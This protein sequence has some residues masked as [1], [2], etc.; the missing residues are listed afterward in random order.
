M[1][2]R[3]LQSEI[4]RV[5][6]R[7]AEGVEAF[8]NTYNKMQASTNLT[9]KEKLEADLKTQIKK[10][11]RLRDQIKTWVASNDI[12][13]KTQLLEN[14]RLIETQMERFK[15]CEKEMKTKA[16]SKEGLIQASK[17]DP[18]AQEK[19]E[20]TQWLR[21]G[22]EELTLQMEQAEAEVETLQGGAKKKKSGATNSRLEDLERLNERRKWHISR[23]EIVLRLLDN[24]SLPVE[25]VLSLKDDVSYF[26]E[27]NTE[28]D[29]DEDE[30]IYDELNLDEEEEKFGLVGDDVDSD[31]ESEDES[32]DIPPRTP[33]KK[34]DDDSPTN[35][36]REEHSP[37][38]RKAG[39]S[40]NLRKSSNVEVPKPPPPISNSSSQPMS[41]IVKN[42]LPPR[43]PI[44]LP[45]RYATAAAAAVSGPPS[46]V[47]TTSTTVHANATSHNASIPSVAAPTN[48][49]QPPA[50]TISSTHPS[51]HDQASSSPSLTQASVSGHSP[52][53]SSASVSGLGDSSSQSQ[54]LSPAISEAMSPSGAP[55]AASSPERTGLATA[56]MPS[57]V[58]VPLSFANQGG[59]PDE[60]QP[61]SATLPNSSSEQQLVPLTQQQ[62]PASSPL[63]QQLQQFNKASSSV[64]GASPLP[65]SN[66]EPTFPPDLKVIQGLER[67]GAG[68][69]AQGMQVPPQRMT[70]TSPSI[71]QQQ[72]FGPQIQQPRSAPSNAFPGSLSDL[73]ASFENVKQKAPH[74]MN[75]LE[76]V[77]KLLD[78]GYQSMPQPLDTEKPKYY[79]PKNPHHTPLYYPQSAHPVLSS[80]SLFQN[81]DI[82]TL[83]YVFYYLP[84]TYQQYLAAKELK[85]QSWRFHV[86]Y[87]TW[88]QRHSEPQAITDEYE[89][90]VY[91]YFDWE[92]SW[93]QRKKSDFRFEYRY[94][95]ED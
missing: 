89:Q 57:S 7:V 20:T 72:A 59:L 81:L 11:Q 14:R 6:K 83:F 60:P 62:M 10:L 42:G 47:I 38:L 35:H 2:A 67:Q 74:R 40:L 66:H 94:L 91:V 54:M 88:F 63:P 1:A 43:P 76:Q 79:V 12:K 33:S 73:V 55:Q 45:V 21:S 52:M 77:H 25:K 58:A 71:Q 84:G 95:S 92:G 3:K 46:S 44:A 29:F 26:V 68:L 51:S 48:G 22:V 19:L 75:N 39:I 90:G 28:D 78:G 56:S 37:I 16:F 13:D 82:E 5:L 23:L 32:E 80:P 41:S 36:K 30:G 27:S 86:K 9:Q 24:G 61:A 87:L 70:S 18:K 15:A 49:T 65:T 17:L 34:A 53:L 31:A 50:S 69:S 64:S 85:R 4:E 93:C 8:D